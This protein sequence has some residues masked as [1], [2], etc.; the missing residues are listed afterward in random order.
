[1]SLHYPYQISEIMKLTPKAVY[2]M[3]K[4]LAE[5]QK[6]KVLL[7]ARLLGLGASDEGSEEKITKE[8][9][10]IFEKPKPVEKITGEFFGSKRRRK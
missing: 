8:D 10:E 4:T 2:I 5:E 7:F 3:T 6:E 1:M 9:L